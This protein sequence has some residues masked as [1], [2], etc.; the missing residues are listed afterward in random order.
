[1]ELIGVL[2]D[3]VVIVALAVLG[4]I[5][6]T[7]GGFLGVRSTRAIARLGR[8]MMWTGYVIT[9]ASVMLFVVAGFVSNR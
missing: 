2:A 7:A 5:M 8:M 4:A 6:A 9:F 1:M 3:K